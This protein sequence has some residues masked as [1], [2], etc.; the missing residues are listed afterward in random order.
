M[1]AGKTQRVKEGLRQEFFWLLG[2][3]RWL[4]I[5][6]FGLP[7][8]VWIC[9]MNEGSTEL[10]RNTGIQFCRIVTPFYFLICLKLTSDGVLRGSGAMKAFM[11]STFADLL[12]RVVLAF[13]FASSG[14]LWESGF[15]GLWAGRLEPCFLWDFIKREVGR[16]V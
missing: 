5:L 11:V 12:L 8:R 3:Q 16:E 2:L 13:V 14:A 7:G 6:L 4:F 9:F 1:G 15:P 10:A